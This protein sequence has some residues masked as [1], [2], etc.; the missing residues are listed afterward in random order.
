MLQL[1]DTA[2]FCNLPQT[3]VH[4][5]ENSISTD[6]R[7]GIEIA[8]N[9][10]QLRLEIKAYLKSKNKLSH[11]LDYAINAHIYSYLMNRKEILPEYVHKKL[12][13]IKLHL[14]ATFFLKRYIRSILY[15]TKENARLF[16]E[17][18]KQT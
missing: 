3:I 1:D 14:P 16:F 17:I 6:Y 2:I 11:T 13:E 4:A 8:N 9:H 5:I 7:R 10:V 18:G 15:A 12:K